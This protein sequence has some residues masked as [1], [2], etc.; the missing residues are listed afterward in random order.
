MLLEEQTKICPYRQR[1]STLKR[2]LLINMKQYNSE[3]YQTSMMTDNHINI[4]WQ[5][6]ESVEE[7]VQQFPEFY[8]P[9]S[10]REI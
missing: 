1:Y 3:K 10:Q 6:R 9:E 5:H 4:S 8:H 2:Q 7:V